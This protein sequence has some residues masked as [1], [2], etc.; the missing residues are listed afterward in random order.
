MPGTFLGLEIARRALQVNRQAMNITGNN[1]ANANTP[2][3][4]RQEAV[5]SPSLPYTDYS[6]C[7]QGGA[8]QWG[9][10]VE[11][12]EVRRVRDD[13]LDGQVRANLAEAGYWQARQDAL[14]RVEA[15]FPETSG[16]S[17]QN[18][19]DKFFASWHDLSQDPESTAARAN[20][21]ET[22]DLLAGG[23]RFAY[24]QLVGIRR[25]QEQMLA[26]GSAGKIRRINE[27]AG[28][29]AELN[30]EIVRAERMGATPAGLMDKRNLPLEELAG[31]LNIDVINKS[32]GAVTVNIEGR[33]L[34][35]GAGGT[36]N[37]IA[38]N[39]T[40]D[41]VVWRDD[42]AEITAPGGSVG[43]LL[44]VRER[45]AG[46]LAALDDL[47]SNLAAK[48]NELNGTEF[49]KSG[50]T[51]ADIGVSNEVRNDLGKING[52]KSLA[53]AGLREELTMAGGTATF[54]S[55][56]QG[57]LVGEIASAGRN[58]AL[59][60][61]GRQAVQEQLEAHRQSVAGVSVDEELTRVI[62]Y[63]YAYQASARMV[64]TYDQM[65]ETLL[66]ML[67]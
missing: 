56:Y 7:R 39:D 35:D 16:N 28:Q 53:I 40:G 38:V 41:G 17:L 5:L 48:V 43:G 20:V 52:Q 27:L 19:M 33:A 10:G 8:A 22:A 11:I 32:G 2:G 61:E 31:L 64:T 24:T 23:I 60:V 55:F 36:V 9:A 37:A 29:V 65:L 46:Y 12:S 1:I 25:D 49:F 63:Q 66:N 13:H 3:Y 45:I 14:R 50:L 30:K 18:L 62:Q 58:A 44:A 34:V 47:A 51:A 67:R 57:E 15:V 42:G 26:D 6:L 54:E 4:T 59:N 21:R